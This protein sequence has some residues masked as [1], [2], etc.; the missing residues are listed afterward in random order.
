MEARALA[1]RGMFARAVTLYDE[2]E[3]DGAPRAQVL[4]GRA[5]LALLRGEP[6]EAIRVASQAIRLGG[7]T[8][9]LLVRAR[10]LGQRGR[11]EESAADLRLVLS[12]EPQNED[13]RRALADVR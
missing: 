5:E 10:A 8:A 2:L 4:T 6:A 9:P 1:R 3:R 7:G 13:A 11:R 12:R